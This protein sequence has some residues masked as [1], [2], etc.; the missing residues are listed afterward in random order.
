[1]LAFHARTEA[2]LR[3]RLAR[4]GLGEASDEAI[5]WLRRL[6]YLDDVAYA[7]GRARALLA[8]GR[9]PRLAARRLAAE[10]VAE[11]AA[12]AAVAE[13]LVGAAEGAPSP[14]GALCRA[15]LARKL[16][17]EALPDDARDRARL[18]RFLLARGFSAE[19]VRRALDLDVDL[20]GGD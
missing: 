1:V 13:A 18:A 14:E 11:G 4:A 7:R 16:R 12:R 17:G 3:V 10:G 20:D 5:A 2:Q 6:G 9:G 19:A 15:A 8:S